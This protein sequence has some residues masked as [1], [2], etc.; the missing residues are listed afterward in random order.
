[1]ARIVIEVSDEHKELVAAIEA[2]AEHV[3]QVAD[4]AA[5][6]GKSVDYAKVER[7]VADKTAAVER[8][9]HQAILR[10][11]DIDAPKVRIDG[12]SWSRVG[13]YEATYY[14]MAG[15]VEVTRSVYRRDGERTGRVFAER[16][17][18]VEDAMITAYQLPA[19]ARSVSASVDRVSLPMAE[20]RPRPPGR[21]KKGAAKQPIT[22]AWRM[23]WAATVTLHDRDGNALHTIRHGAM[24]DDG[25]ASLLHG[26]AGD[27]NELLAKK[28]RRLAIEAGAVLQLRALATSD[29]WADAMDLTLQPLRKA[30]RVAA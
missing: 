2:L 26:V 17:V 8:A 21:P 9:A 12:A 27:L 22:V 11:L 30:V 6:G 25:A 15:P 14:T 7:M 13:R 20:P 5:V 18:E 1:V 24:P 3:T 29:R 4:R 23:A 10:R 19:E 28:P 16:Q